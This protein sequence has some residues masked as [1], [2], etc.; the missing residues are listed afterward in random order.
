MYNEITL[1]TGNEWKTR[2][3]TQQEMN[4]QLEKQCTLLEEKIDE[5]RKTLAEGMDKLTTSQ[6]FKQ[7]L[8]KRTCEC[9]F[10]I[11]S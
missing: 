11:L 2:F 10:I 7:G 6:N 4:Q 5:A 1:I 3:E 8:S 9:A